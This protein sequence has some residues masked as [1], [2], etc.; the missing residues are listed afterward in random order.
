MTRF[1][2]ALRRLV[3]P[4]LL[5]APGVAYAEWGINMTPGV[6][7]ISRK[8]YDLHMLIFS[9]CV[10][11]GIVVFGAMIWSIIHHRK[12]R[13]MVAEQFHEST[14]LEIVWTIIPFLILVG[15]A[16]PAT[17]VLLAMED[18][19]ASEVNIK[20]TAYQWKWRYDYLGED[21]QPE[22]GF[23]STLDAASNA[24]RQLGSGIDP[25]TVENYLLNV[26][27]PIV[28]P[29]GRKVRLLLTSNDV[30][31]SWWVPAVGG[32]K[33]A[34]PGYVQEFWFNIEEPG[35]YRGQCAELCGRDH[36]FMPI[37]L[38]AKTPAEYDAWVAERKGGAVAEAAAVEAAA[39]KLWSRDELMAKGKE[40]YDTFC[41]ACHM[42]DGSGNPALQAK[43]IKG[44]AIATGDLKAHLDIVLHGKPGTAMAAFGP[45]MSDLDI[46]A[47]VTYERNAFGNDKGD[48]VQP[49]DVKA[50][51]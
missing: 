6:T 2:G 4:G 42:P 18:F 21:A 35:V 45:Q 14:L 16:W 38:V 41:A 36:G 50:A 47:V 20:V 9:I 51:R 7:E 26:D 32:K 40:V 43:P 48:V 37:V 34:I 15:M 46:A 12:S 5:L 22:F 24:A 11:I 3:V 8:V 10:V 17:K 33:D 1:Y 29:T 25:A 49:A 23:F 13:G 30:I 28:V 27:N 39:D 31:H 19:R 44:G